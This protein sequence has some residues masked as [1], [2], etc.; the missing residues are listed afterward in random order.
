MF[1]R[2]GRDSIKGVVEHASEAVSDPGVRDEG[3]VGQPLDG[4]SQQPDLSERIRLSGEQEPRREAKTS[5]R[6]R[7][8]LLDAEGLGPR[9]PQDSRLL[10]RLPP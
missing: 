10:F 3:R 1:A 4:A 7:V 8:L 6:S 5:S 2:E 9:K